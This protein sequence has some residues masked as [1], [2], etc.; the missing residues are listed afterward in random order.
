MLENVSPTF[1]SN[2][3]VKIFKNLQGNNKRKNIL[4]TENCLFCKIQT[5][6]DILLMLSFIIV[7]ILK[8]TSTGCIFIGPF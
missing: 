7:R 6:Q 8:T 2:K 4:K 5:K 3:C 1:H